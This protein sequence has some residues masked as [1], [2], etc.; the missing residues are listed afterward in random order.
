MKPYMSDTT[1]ASAILPSPFHPLS[2]LSSPVSP[3][4]PPSLGSSPLRPIPFRHIG[5]RV[6]PERGEPGKEGGKA[7]GRKKK[8]RRAWF[9]DVNEVIPVGVSGKLRT[10]Y[11]LQSL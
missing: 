11:S 5:F 1:L 10:E 8:Q 6:V 4:L 9:I 3:S 2:S 7:R